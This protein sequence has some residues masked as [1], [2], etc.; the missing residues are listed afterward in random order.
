M[1]K[2]IMGINVVLVW[3][4]GSLWGRSM[5]EVYMLLLWIMILLLVVFFLLN[6]LDILFFG[7]DIVISFGE[8]VK[9]LRIF[10]LVLVVVL[11]GFLVVI[12]GIIGFV[13]FIVLYMVR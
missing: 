12:V 2:N 8:N 6:K 3:L 10:F 5:I 1:V 11:I 9:V 4:L 13:G 7:D